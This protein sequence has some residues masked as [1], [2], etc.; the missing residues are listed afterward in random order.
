MNTSFGIWSHKAHVRCATP[1]QWTL[2][3]FFIFV[4]TNKMREGRSSVLY[5]QILVSWSLD[6][7]ASKKCY[8]YDHFFCGTSVVDPW[9]FGTEPDPRIR[10]TDLWIRIRILLFSS[11]AFKM[12]TKKLV[13]FLGF[14]LMTFWRN[15]TCTSVFKD[16]KSWRSH[17]TVGIKVFLTFLLDDGRIRIRTNNDVSGPRKPIPS[18]SGYSTLTVTEPFNNE[19]INKLVE[20]FSSV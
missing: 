13:F 7:F 10:T 15:C 5:G 8:L 17:K 2:F 12:P 1:C 3:I 14:L 9:H 19:L 11:V 6:V 20:T 4:I 18:G 16:I